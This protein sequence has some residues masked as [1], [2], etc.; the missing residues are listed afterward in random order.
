MPLRRT[1]SATCSLGRLVLK[2][3]K[4][5]PMQLFL[6]LCLLDGEHQVGD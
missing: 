4:E 1:S 6:F 3:K 5:L 2:K